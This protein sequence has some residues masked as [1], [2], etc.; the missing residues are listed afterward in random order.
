MPVLTY[1]FKPHA[2]QL[3]AMS[4]ITDELLY[5]GAAGGGKSRWA[6]AEGVRMCVQVP[7]CRVILFRRTRGDLERAVVD[8]LRQEIPRGLARYVRNRHQWEFQNGSVFELAY[9]ENDA[10][11]EN[12]QGAE[13]QLAIFEELTQFSAKQYR[14]LLSRLRTNS[15]TVKDRMNELGIPSRMIATTNPGGPGHGWVKERWVDHL[16]HGVP[17]TPAVTELDPEPLERCYIP[18]KLSD[19]PSLDQ[20]AYRKQL[21]S[22]DPTMRRALLDGDWDI[23]EGVRFAQWRKNVHVIPPDMPHL[24]LDVLAG[25]PRVVA[26]DYGSEAPFCAL[27]G[28]LLPD[29]LV[30]IY[31][32]AY[33]TGLTP[34][35]QVELM[36]SL[37]VDGERM[38]P[39]RPIPVVMDPAMWIR[40][41]NNLLKAINRDE[42]PPGSIAYTYGRGFGMGTIVRA[43]NSRIDG[44][45][46]VDEH[47]RVRPDGLPR[48]LVMETCTN[49]IRTLPSV[50]R[51]KRHPEDVD[52]KSEDHAADALR[53][54]LMHYARGARPRGITTVG[55]RP[56]PGTASLGDRQF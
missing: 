1:S 18:A 48:L 42:P 28:A 27:W 21:N 20:V 50:P 46:L 41:P 47:L 56:A 2:R 13:Y 24:N 16:P 33:K 36:K 53:Y 35:E 45:A 5:G 26:V 11:L 4:T 49:L 40:G 30:V 29:N 43:I 32:E 19:N 9:L 44:W 22:Q 38:P 6:R 52:T 10:D 15:Q 23:L 55:R 8:Y 12:Y 14:Y 17:F 39:T 54:L 34:L 3:T 51:D 37:E 31:R 25:F 7:G